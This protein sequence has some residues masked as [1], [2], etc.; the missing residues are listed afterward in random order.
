LCRE[1][2]SQVVNGGNSLQLEGTT[3][4]N[5][6]NLSFNGGTGGGGFAALL[7]GSTQ[8]NVS[9]FTGIGTETYGLYFSADSTG[10]RALNYYFPNATTPLNDLAPAGSNTTS[11]SGGGGGVSAAS[12]VFTGNLSAGGGT[13]LHAG[14]GTEHSLT[15]SGGNYVEKYMNVVSA[16][17]NAKLTREI[18]RIDLNGGCVFQAMTDDNG[19]ERSIFGWSRN[20]DGSPTQVT[21]ETG[22]RLSPI[23]TPTCN[24]ANRFAFNAVAGA[25]GAK[26]VVQVCAKDA[27][28]TYA[29]R[30][31][32]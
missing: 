7:T 23:A 8:N 11:A 27:T 13:Q 21:F 5:L 16:G 24:A 2:S 18:C 28:D 14:D 19:T 30:Q 10:N 4:N 15:V 29:W 12:G 20:A 17:I 3:G 26:D 1:R 6:S 9:N 25:A 22:I 32:Y 31:I